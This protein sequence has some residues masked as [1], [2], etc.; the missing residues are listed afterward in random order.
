MCKCLWA[1]PKL[2]PL[3]QRFENENVYMNKWI[4]LMASARR[5]WG[6]GLNPPTGSDRAR[7]SLHQRVRKKAMDSSDPYLRALSSLLDTSMVVLN[8]NC[9]MNSHARSSQVLRRA[10]S[11]NANHCCATPLKDNVNK[12]ANCVSSLPRNLMTKL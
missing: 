7:G 11:N 10:R 2:K 3:P 8:K 5:P 6:C 12:T 4:L 1:C 9:L